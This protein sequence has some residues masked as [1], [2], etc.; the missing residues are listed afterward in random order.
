MGLV[1]RVSVSAALLAAASPGTMALAATTTPIEHVIIIVGEN[2]TFDNLFGTYK[3]KAG[4]TI[5]N[6]LSKGIVSADGTPGP[7]F[8]KAAQRI[9]RDEVHYNVETATA[10]SYTTLPQPWTTSA[11]PQATACRRTCPTPA[12]RPTCP[13][14]RTRSANTFLTRP[15]P[16]TRPSLFPD[17]AADR[18][19]QER[20]V[21]LG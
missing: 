2:H 5:D 10:G 18:W 6:L 16:A 8:N 13:M 21:R 4:Q 19:R 20:Q 12:F 15:I 3:P 9:G 11:P 17:V 1:N 7:H 14:V